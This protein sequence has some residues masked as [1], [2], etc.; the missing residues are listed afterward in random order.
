M[1]KRALKQKG[2]EKFSEPKMVKYMP[3]KSIQPRLYLK[4]K[5]FY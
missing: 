1:A 2:S 5:R 3:R 4:Q